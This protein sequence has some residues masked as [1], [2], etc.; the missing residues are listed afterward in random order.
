LKIASQNAHAHGVADRI[1]FVQADLLPSVATPFDLV[2]ANLPYIPANVLPELK[3]YQQEP[4]HALD[5]GMDGLECIHRLL[6]QLPGRLSTGGLALLEIGADQ[7]DTGLSLARQ[8]FP[9][10]KIRVLPDL[11]GLDRL[12]VIHIKEE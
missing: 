2:C 10:A 8:A 4:M 12:L 6:R 5:G 3:T 11:A 7:G 9:K 1:D